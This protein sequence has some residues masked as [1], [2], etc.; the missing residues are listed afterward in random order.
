MNE[1][2]LLN[3]SVVCAI[4]GIAILLLVQTKFEYET[5]KIK[6]LEMGDFVKITGKVVSEKEYDSVT[7]LMI[8]D[9]SENI[10]VFLDKNVNFQKNMEVSVE[11]KVTE[12]KG[13]KQ[14]TASK[15][16]IISMP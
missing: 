14:I 4:A 1:K 8:D 5:T 16:G 10:E 9:G 3:V 7:I 2:N 6:D 12:Y 11:G 13:R 15:I